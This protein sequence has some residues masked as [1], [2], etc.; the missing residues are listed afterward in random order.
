MSGGSIGT[1]LGGIVGGIIGFF[2]GGPAGIYYGAMVGATLG[3][4]VGSALDPPKGPNQTGPR[5]SDLT[6]Q[7]STYGAF[8]P[9][10]YGSIAVWGN[11]FWIENN[12]LKEVET[13]EKTG[14]KGGGGLATEQTTYAYYG[15]FALGLC[16]GPITGTGRIWIGG[17]LRYEPGSPTAVWDAQF[18]RVYRGTEDQMPDSRMQATLGVANTPAYRGLAY[19][20]FYDLP[21]KDWGNS[22]AALQIKVEVF[23]LHTTG[24][25]N[26]ICQASTTATPGPITASENLVFVIRASGIGGVYEDTLQVWYCGD[27]DSPLLLSETTTTRWTKKIVNIKN[28]LLV[29]GGAG[30]ADQCKIYNIANPFNP[31]L[32]STTALDTTYNLKVLE[33][34]FYT[35]YYAGDELR[36]YDYQKPNSVGLICNMTIGNKPYYI[37]AHGNYLYIGYYDTEI[38]RFEIYDISRPAHPELIS[39][40]LTG[41]TVNDLVIDESLLYV[42]LNTGDFQIWDVSNPLLPVLR[43]TSTPSPLH[44]VAAVCN[45]KAYLQSNIYGSFEIWDVLNPDLPVQGASVYTGQAMRGFDVIGDMVFLTN[46]AI[47]EFKIYSPAIVNGT[48]G[49]IVSAETLNSNLLTAA[50]IDVTELTQIVRGFRASQMGAIR[51]TIEPLRGAYFFDVVQHGYKI[52]FLRRG[53]SSIANITGD[54]LDARSAGENNGISITNSREMDSQLPQ[55]VLVK[56]FDSTRE[57]DT[58]EQYAERINTDAVNVREIET[59]VVLI[60]SEAAQIATSLLYLYWMERYNIAFKLPPEYVY[61]EPGDIITITTNTAVY[62]LRLISISYTAKG[63][64]ECLARYNQSAL[65]TQAAVLGVEGPPATHGVAVPGYSHYLLL[66][67]PLLDDV[68]DTPGFP[69]AMTGYLTGWPGGIIYRSE[70]GGASW[71]NLQGFSS[72]GSKIGYATDSLSVH[73][74]CTMDKSGLL[75]VKMFHSATLASVTEA[76][77]FTG[78]NWFAYGGDQRWEIIAAQNCVLQGDGS[79]ILTDFLRGQFGTEWATG[80]HAAS[81]SIVHLSSSELKFILMNSSSIG[82]EKLYRGITAG[83]ALDTDS[84]LEFTYN[85]VNLECLSPCHLSG[86]RHPTTNNWTLTWTRRSRFGA[87][88]DL[89][90]A[91]LGETTENYQIEIY[92]DGTYAVIKRTLTATSQTVSYTSAEQVTDFGSNQGTLYLKIYQLSSVVGTGYPLTASITR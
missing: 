82:V 68:Y 70:D 11:I 21:L 12:S 42:S 73:D 57:Y 59:P 44:G 66:D 13:T 2:V 76:Q 64:L 91:T 52:K 8:I 27:P 32:L 74:G 47:N 14:G 65:Y 3:G 29:F 56:Y 90:D 16:E 55:K 6:V 24:S 28:L 43:S 53:G 41:A 1:V 5:L 4:A 79:Y 37:T 75:T 17:Q 54:E 26:L 69:A 31:V 92:A 60:A 35:V 81:D 88:R 22:L 25:S 34:Y 80:L 48:L 39:S 15:T 36:I 86:N 78:Q 87:W 72:S 9:R 23:G 62:E 71:H 51:A 77:M 38:Q 49:A 10:I 33:D 61:L 20:V 58:G 46:Y 84:D 45:N 40:T 50:D 19:I 89:V 67:I 85:G 7:T 18:F 83:R 63:Y 30:G